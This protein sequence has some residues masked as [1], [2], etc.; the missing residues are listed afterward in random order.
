[1]VARWA[2]PPG[3]FVGWPV[4]STG[5][6][7]V[8]EHL[9]YTSKRSAKNFWRQYRIFDDRVELDTLFKTITVPFGEVEGVEVANSFAEALRMPLRGGRMAIKLD[10][11][12]FHKHVV[13][14]RTTG[15][16]RHIAFTPDDPEAFRTVLKAAMSRYRAGRGED[17]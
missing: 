4:V 14:D 1:M 8:E 3:R 15:V 11:A 5:V 16:F 9:L 2:R 12:D 10:W 13:L 17:G 6:A 7:S